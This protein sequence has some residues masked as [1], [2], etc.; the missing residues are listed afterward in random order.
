[1]LLPEWLLAIDGTG[2]GWYAVGSLVAVGRISTIK[3]QEG[4]DFV[5]LPGLLPGH[6]RERKGLS[7]LQKEETCYETRF[8]AN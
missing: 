6:R 4:P 8:Y 2:N 7:T 3:K 5:A 1:M